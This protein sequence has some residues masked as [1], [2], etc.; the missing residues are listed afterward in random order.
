MCMVCTLYL[1][2]IIFFGDLIV[3]LFSD[4]KM[5]ESNHFHL[6]KI[7]CFGF[8]VLWETM[9]NALLLSYIHEW[10]QTLVITPKT[11]K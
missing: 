9:T 11:P 7:V 2:S 1:F 6:V 3:V 10:S 5:W 4:F 8:D